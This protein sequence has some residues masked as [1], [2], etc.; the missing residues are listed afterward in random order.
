MTVRTEY[1]EIVGRQIL[2]VAVNVLDLN[3]DFSAELIALR[4][5]AS[6]T[7]LTQRLQQM[8]T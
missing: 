5:P 7:A 1:R 8:L 4:P 6:L 2:P 3:G